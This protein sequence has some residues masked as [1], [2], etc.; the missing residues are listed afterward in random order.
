MIVI[1]F[2]FIFAYLFSV[3]FG[4]PGGSVVENPLANA[5]DVVLILGLGRSL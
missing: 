5:G 3:R 2:C 4:F 1:G